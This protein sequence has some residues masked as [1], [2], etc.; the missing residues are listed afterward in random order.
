MEDESVHFVFSFLVLQHLTDSEI[1]LRYI[2]EC[3]RVLRPSC[4]AFL[5]FGTMATEHSPDP[6]IPVI[7]RVAQRLAACLP[8]WLVSALRI[9]KRRLSWLPSGSPAYWWNVGLWQTTVPP[10]PDLTEDI[11]RKTVWR[12]CRVPIERVLETCAGSG[13][14]VRS[15]D[16]IGTQYTFL[17]AVK[18][19]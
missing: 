16:G 10:R 13:L 2:R 14:T 4:V 17:T 12:G 9:L 5:Q 3:A 7:P 6:G 8:A 11:T 15:L 18:Q 19:G 1:V